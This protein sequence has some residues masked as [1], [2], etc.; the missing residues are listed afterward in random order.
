MLLGKL[1]PFFCADSPPMLHM[2]RKYWVYIE[3][4]TT[5]QP[6]TGSLHL[7]TTPEAAHACVLNMQ[8]VNCHMMANIPRVLQK[9]IYR[10]ITLVSNKHNCHVWV[11]MLPSILKPTRQVIERFSPALHHF[12]CN[13]NARIMTG[14]GAALQGGMPGNIIH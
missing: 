10:Q 14:Q 11:S 4:V 13:C 1:F 7:E 9:Q 3:Q 5:V 12:E 6:C 2:Q 8:H